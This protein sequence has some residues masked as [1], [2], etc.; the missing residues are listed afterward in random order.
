[1]ADDIRAT[2]VRSLSLR[3]LVAVHVM[4]VDDDTLRYFV[5]RLMELMVTTPAPVFDFRMSELAGRLPLWQPEEQAAV[6]LFAEAVWSELLSSHPAALGYFSDVPTALDLLEW[7]GLSVIEHLDALLAAGTPAA[8][9]HLADLVDVMC[10]MN[11]PFESVSSA[12]VFT[13]LRDAGTGER[14][15]QAFYGADSPETARLLSD[16][17]ELWAVCCR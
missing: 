11:E 2:P 7:C 12:R 14:L 1:S 15:E 5:P 6:R 10:T 16:A 8:A 13:W 4:S 3:Q 9:L 17:H